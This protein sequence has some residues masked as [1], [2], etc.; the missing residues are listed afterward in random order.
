[1]YMGYVYLLNSWDDETYKIGVSKYEDIS[2]RIKQLQTGNP[3][4]IILLQKYKSE[5]YR[6]IE[7]MLHRHFGTQHKRG[8]WFKLEDEQVLNFACKCEE[9]DNMITMLLKENPYYK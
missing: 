6:K 1:M 2:K 5:N 4:E 8:E 3:S 7:T 9:L